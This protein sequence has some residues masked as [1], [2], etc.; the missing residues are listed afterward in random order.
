MRKFSQLFISGLSVL[1]LLSCCKDEDKDPDPIEKFDETP[2]LSNLSDHLIVPA[3][4]VITLSS[5]QLSLSVNDFITTP[6]Q[7]TLDQ[8][9]SSWVSAIKNWQRTSVYQIGPASDI[10]LRENVNTYPADTTA[11]NTNIANG[12]YDLEQVS[13]YDAK[14]FQAMDYL[15]FG[16]A[17]TDA[18]VLEKY[19][20]ATHF[21]NRKQYLK[22]IAND[23]HNNM[24]TV[25]QGWENSYATTFKNA[26][27]V[28]IGSSV[29]IMLNEFNLYF[30]R[31][32]RD[33][34]VG[35]PSGARTFTQ[36]PLPEKCEAYY[37]G[38]ISR[39]LLI[40]SMKTMKN[41]YL[42]N[43]ANGNEGTGFDDFLQF[44]N[45]KY[46]DA[47]LDETIQSQLDVVIAGSENLGVSIAEEATSNQAKLLELFDDMQFL[48]SLLKVEMTNS[49]EV[50]ITYK[51]SD[52]D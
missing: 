36:T 45:A 33:G 15:L 1:V 28:D 2:L 22:D 16:I 18:E 9:R 49:M 6:S 21:Q 26:A 42:G 34:K 43:D 27:G 25:Q 44:N 52:G 51:D 20:T 35:I 17:D 29:G 30:E 14:G 50:Q 46:N 23:L 41:V 37:Y 13:N 24:I 5:E 38:T 31:Y 47:S 10:A 19:T 48:N 39:D 12:S 4:G 40:E 3:Y 8:V 11:I 7:T 32:V